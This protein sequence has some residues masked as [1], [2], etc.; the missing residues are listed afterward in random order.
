[1]GKN[2]GGR[3]KKRVGESVLDG[4][5]PRPM[6]VLRTL[7][8]DLPWPFNKVDATYPVFVVVCTKV[9]FSLKQNVQ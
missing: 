2:L 3:W 1:M 4:W 7:A 5:P 9:G 8:D 6:P